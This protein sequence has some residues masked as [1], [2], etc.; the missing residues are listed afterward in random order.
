MHSSVC[1]KSMTI[2]LHPSERSQRVQI[3][4]VC[5]QIFPRKVVAVVLRR[6]EHLHSQDLH[7]QQKDAQGSRQA[8]SSCNP[9]LILDRV[10][11]RSQS[12]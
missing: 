8:G 11:Q 2:A 7:A 12:D 5:R 10:E 3:G 1:I 9:P 4:I 6:P